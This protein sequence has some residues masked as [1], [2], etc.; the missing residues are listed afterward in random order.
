MLTNL[1]KNIFGTRNTR[2]LKDYKSVVTEINDL[3]EKY[4]K[5]SEIDFTKETDNL[6]AQAQTNE[7]LSKLLPNAFALVREASIRTL[8]LRHYDEQLMGGIA[9][10]NGKIAEMKTGEGKTL[11]STL[12]AYLNSLKN[13]H[14]FIVT[15]N[16][17]LA[18]RDAEWMGQIFKFLGLTVGTIT[19]ALSPDQRKEVY[20]CNIVYGTN[21]EFGFDYLRDNMTY[22]KNQKVQGELSF[23]IIDEV[24][25]VL[26]DEARTPLIISGSAKETGNLYLKV[27]KTTSDLIKKNKDNELYVIDEKQKS[28][29]LTE[30]GHSE[31]ENILVSNNLITSKESLYE[32]K[33]IQL[34][35]L[36]DA[37]L[38]ANLMYHKDIDYVVENNEIIIIDEFSG[39]KMPGRRWSEGLHQSVEAKEK[40]NIQ[41]ENQTYASITFQNYF[42]QFDKLAGMTGTADTEATEFQQIYNLEVIVIPPHRKM[43]RK[44]HVDLIYLTAKEKYNAIIKEV[45]RVHELKQPILVGTTS[46]ESSE[47]ISSI[48]KKEKIKHSVLN[49][50]HHQM[51]ADIIANAGTLGAVTI[52]T[53][54]AGRGTDIVLG[55]RN[56]KIDHNDDS[57]S[58][59]NI[60]KLGGLFIIGTERHESR[61]VDNQLRGRS[62]RQGDPGESRFFLSLEDNL[63][64]IFA[65]EKVSEIMK[66]LGMQEGE[67]I[68]H[69]W[70][71]KS[72]ENAQ[73][74]VESHNFDIR[75]TLLEF[76]D[77]SNEQRKVIYNQRDDILSSDNM[78]KIYDNILEYTCDDILLSYLPNDLPSSQW[79]FNQIDSGLKNDFLIEIDT[80]ATLE[81]DSDNNRNDLKNTIKKCINDK[82]TSNLEILD[83]NDKKELMRNI[84]LS[85]I[86]EDWRNHL[87]SIDYLRQGI[88]L[89]SYAQ[90]NP[91]NE[92]KRESFEMFE[93][94][95]SINNLEIIK[96][97]CKIKI[98]KSEI[99]DIVKND[100]LSNDTSSLEKKSDDPKCLLNNSDNG[101]SRNAKCPVTNKK[102]KQCCGKL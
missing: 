61:R 52:A 23:A 11:V 64:R 95:L 28:V 101:V 92:Y 70:V 87:N 2:I 100:D 59:E 39:R 54:M 56:I 40:V 14:V 3:E 94:M 83:K 34:L 31:I 47:F 88:G 75:K 4:Q 13:K 29:S 15:V 48:L 72:I 50:K 60:K 33:N 53:N 45:K 77:I 74:R 57:G 98:K 43:I 46:I 63:M 51:E 76:D 90:K 89:R 12:P 18:E 17:Y 24:D 38:K 41:N 10:H 86:D 36:V 58:S 68:E 26:I 32:P 82:V 55:G 7:D 65:S 16:D 84:F 21:N 73:K 1:I 99:S 69:K 81:S 96:V 49:A 67:A 78:D 9:L 80:K 102:F 37:S 44:D 62:G 6:R 30:S 5:F 25:S 22:D 42:R 8:G 71:S 19:S 66:K 27:N 35:H 79:D 20:K 93:E 91:K 97:L 85:V